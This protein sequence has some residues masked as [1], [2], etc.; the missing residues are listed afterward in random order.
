M[1]PVK[2]YNSLLIALHALLAVLIVAALLAGYFLVAATPNSDPHKFGLLAV[3]MAGGMTILALTA[4]RFVVRLTSARPPAAPTG[5]AAL[6]ALA[7]AT[8]YGFYLLIVMMAATGLATAAL[9]GVNQIVFGGS[10]APLPPT[11]AVY[12]SRIVHGDLAALLAILIVLHVAGAFYHQ[13]VLKDGLMG[14]MSFR[15][16]RREDRRTTP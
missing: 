2:R 8:H 3:H 9:S 12:P 10:G 5:S 13:L 1:P 4:L 7:T 6:D 15:G 16:V 14:R 11:L